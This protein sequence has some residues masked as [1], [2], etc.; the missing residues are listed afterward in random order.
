L[1]TR[2]ELMALEQR[3]TS[4]ENDKLMLEVQLEG[5]M[6]AAA[7]EA[8]Y[9]T[10]SGLIHQQQQQQQQQHHH[11]HQQQQ[12]QQHQNPHPMVRGAWLAKT[13]R[14]FPGSISTRHQQGQGQMSRTGPPHPPLP[15]LPPPFS[16]VLRPRWSRPGR[17]MGEGRADRAANQRKLV[18]PLPTLPPAPTRTH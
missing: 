15:P 14:P 7:E 16:R 11:H 2:D 10:S 18:P 5:A 13:P 12:Q 17:F 1:L 3:R 4:L 6:R 8:G 9:E